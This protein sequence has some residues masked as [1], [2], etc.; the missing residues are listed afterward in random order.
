VLSGIHGEGLANGAG[1]YDHA[2]AEA[3]AREADVAPI[4]TI[5]HFVW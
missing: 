4:A 1:G 2:K 3:T 5:P